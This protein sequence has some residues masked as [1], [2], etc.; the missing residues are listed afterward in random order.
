VT[1]Q[2]TAELSHRTDLGA[3]GNRWRLQ[4]AFHTGRAGYPAAAQQLLAPMLD[5][6]D[7]PGDEDAARAVL[8]AVGGPRADI[9]LQIVGLEAELAVL[10]P[11]ADD[12]R[13]RVHHALA[14]DYHQ[15]GDH[16]RALAHGQQELLLRR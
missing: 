14:A 7:F 13:L 4:L 2:I 11:D 12:D 10:P 9:R 3:V 5:A 1:D 15:L 6:R 8:Y 16:R